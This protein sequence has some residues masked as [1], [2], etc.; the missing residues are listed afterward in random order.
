MPK[1]TRGDERG[2][3][4][5]AVDD[6]EHHYHHRHPANVADHIAASKRLAHLIGQ[7]SKDHGRKRIADHPKQNTVPE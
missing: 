4:L 7:S 2:Q 3:L 1:T 5:H 6:N